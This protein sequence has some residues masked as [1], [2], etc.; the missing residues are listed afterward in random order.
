MRIAITGAS[1]FLTQQLLPYLQADQNEFVYIGR[2]KEHL[3][4]LFGSKAIVANYDELDTAFE[5]VA[6][7]LHFAAMI[8]T[9]DAVYEAYEKANVELTKTVVQAA[10]SSGVKLLI[11]SSR[12]NVEDN[13]NSFYGISKLEAEKYLSQHAGAM[14]I[15][16]LA[17][18]AIYGNDAYSG[19]L[20]ILYKLPKFLR[21]FFFYILSALKPTV[22]IELVADAVKD[23]LQNPKTLY[24]SLTDRQM[25]NPFYAFIMRAIDLSFCFAV[26]LLF[27][28]LL[29]IVWIAIKFTSVGPGIFSQQ[30]IG[31]GGEEFTCYKFRTMYK[32]TKIA[33]TH[34][35]GK[36]SVTKIGK[37]IRKFKIDELPQIWN[38]LRNEMSLVGPRP[39]LPI[40]KELIEARKKQG[41][42]D[43]KCGLTGLAQVRGIDMSIP[44]VLAEVDAEYSKIRTI[45]LNIKL[46]LQTFLGSGLEDRVSGPSPK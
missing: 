11:F 31:L 13:R 29:I 10:K 9:K 5:G 33:G 23:A 45:T 39:C 32:D 1:G 15:V 18:P 16:T 8:P 35:L 42:L 26:I 30:R 21:G 3:A 37:T 17:L 38:I 2:D 44:N 46:I 40:Q 36:A 25:P 4:K 24:C 6:A 28:W 27:W 7:V 41:V 20:K 14:P 34:E 43:I 22:N 19:K 12:L